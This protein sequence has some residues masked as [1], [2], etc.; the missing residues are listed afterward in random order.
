MSGEDRI[1]ALEAKVAELEKKIEALSKDAI[2]L[3]KLPHAMVAVQQEAW[4]RGFGR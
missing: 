3:K 4:R 2:T 1:A